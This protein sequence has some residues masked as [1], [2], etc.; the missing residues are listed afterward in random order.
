VIEVMATTNNVIIGVVVV[1]IALLAIVFAAYYA[2]QRYVEDKRKDQPVSEQLPA[3]S[4]LRITASIRGNLVR[5]YNYPIETDYV[6]FPDKELGKGGVGVVYVGQKKENN[7]YYAIK[8]VNKIAYERE[9]ARLERELKLLKDVD[10][11]N[12]VRLFSVYNLP[13]KM[14]FVMELCTGGHLGNFLSRQPQ[15]RLVD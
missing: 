11:T 1:I 7:A 2:Y 6:I 12:I 3:R 14:F 8:Y 10:H 4:S 13:E 9:V 15:K 5:T